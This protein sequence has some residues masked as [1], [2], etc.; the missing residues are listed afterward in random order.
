MEINNH[1]LSFK[2]YFNLFYKKDLH[3]I[4]IISKTV[5]PH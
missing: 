3:Q 1:G 5:I 4:I 2:N